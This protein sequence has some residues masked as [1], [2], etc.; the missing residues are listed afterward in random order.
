MPPSLTLL[1][2]LLERVKVWAMGFKK[3]KKGGYRYEGRKER[4]AL[5]VK[6]SLFFIRNYFIS[7]RLFFFLKS[8]FFSNQFNQFNS[9]SINLI[10]GKSNH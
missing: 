7:D 2:Q 3:L 8:R 1:S 10:R 4:K 9:I 5:L 6:T